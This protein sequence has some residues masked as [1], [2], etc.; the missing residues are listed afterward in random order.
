MN[1][2][3]AQWNKKGLRS[4]QTQWFIELITMLTSPIV[5][6]FVSLDGSALSGLNSCF[7]HLQSIRPQHDNITLHDIFK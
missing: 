7:R 2:I 3:T 6:S 4:L 1:I 5:L